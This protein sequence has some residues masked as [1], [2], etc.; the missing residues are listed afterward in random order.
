MDSV[1]RVK[2]YTAESGAVYQY[3]FVG[4]RDALPGSGERATEYI[5]DILRN[6]GRYSVSI[7]VRFTAVA[8][9]NAGHGRE[10]SG[11]EQYG[12]AKMRLLSAFNESDDVF[13]LGRQFV[14][15]AENIQGLA[16]AL[17]LD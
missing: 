7:F 8:H 16:T 17:N 5:F 15:D 11:S 2:T 10:L 13:A 1:R 6:H 9:W 3:Y 4:W 12:L 14:V